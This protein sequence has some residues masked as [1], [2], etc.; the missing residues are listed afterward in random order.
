MLM[1]QSFLEG[2]TK[3]PW[4]VEGRRDLGGRKERERDKGGQDQ[5]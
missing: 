4:E 2:G 1:V 3:Y 5:V